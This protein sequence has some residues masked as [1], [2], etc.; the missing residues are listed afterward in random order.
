MF[1]QIIP[2]TMRTDATS[3]NGDGFF[4]AAK[5]ARFDAA[6]AIGSDNDFCGKENIASGL[7][8]GLENCFRRNVWAWVGGHEILQEVRSFTPG[9]FGFAQGRQ[10]GR[11]SLHGYTHSSA[12]FFQTQM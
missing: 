12:P 8:A 6:H 9:A 3:D 1:D 10:P 4:V 2:V 7:A 11:L 5:E